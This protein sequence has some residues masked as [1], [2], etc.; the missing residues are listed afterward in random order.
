MILYFHCSY[1]FP[2]WA[3]GKCIIRS[4][5]DSGNDL[6]TG[7]D[8][9]TALHYGNGLKDAKVGVAEITDVSLDG[10]KIQNISNYHSI[11]FHEEF[12]TM[13][14]YY[15]IGEGVKQPYSGINVQPSIKMIKPYHKTD[16]REGNVKK[17][18]SKKREDRRLCTLL[19]CQ[20]VGCSASFD[21]PTELEEHELLGVHTVPTDIS[22]MDKVKKLFVQKMKGNHQTHSQQLGAMETETSADR[23]STLHKKLFGQKGWALPKRND[24]RYTERQNDFLFNFFN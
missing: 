6:L 9:Y 19:F 13:W 4:F 20:E 24:F 22:G 12:V 18:E 1:K 5:V 11:E 21:S 16:K 23:E 10:N 2:E 14:R 7:D 17:Q 8:I 3:A 15:G